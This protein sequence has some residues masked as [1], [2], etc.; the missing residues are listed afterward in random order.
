MCCIEIIKL[1][2]FDSCLDAIDTGIITT[3]LGTWKIIFEFEGIDH[4]YSFEVV[5]VGKVIIPNKFNENYT[6]YFKLVKPDGTL[7]N[8]ICYEIKTQI[9]WKH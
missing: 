3:D 5:T 6:H 2:C 8:G 4:S 1:G 9:I 7:Y